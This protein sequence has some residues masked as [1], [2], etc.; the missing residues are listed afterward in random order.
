MARFA[1]ACGQPP[2]ASLQVVGPNVQGRLGGEYYVL[3][4]TVPRNSDY[5]AMVGSKPLMTAEGT[6]SPSKL[7]ML[8]IVEHARSSM[9]K[10]VGVA[11]RSKSSVMELA[12]AWNR[13]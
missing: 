13:M 9:A 3:K 10:L 8:N 5:Y 12:G 11:H 6:A 4:G 1:G 7:S 2:M